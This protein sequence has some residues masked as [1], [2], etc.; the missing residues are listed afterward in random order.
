MLCV[1]CQWVN[2]DS[3]QCWPS[4]AT[5]ASHAAISEGSVR[6]A[7]KALEEAGAVITER[8]KTEPGTTAGGESKPLNQSN[9]Y[10]VLGYDPKPGGTSMVE[11]GVLQGLKGG[12]SKGGVGVPQPLHPNT[13][14]YNTLKEHSSL[15]PVPNGSGALRVTRGSV[16]MDVQDAVDAAYA[17]PSKRMLPPH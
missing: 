8:R 11:V 12:T 17:K 16:P 4:V 15:A 10:T 7:I 1:L 2:K 6:T 9:L 14:N 13:V 3:G 5:I